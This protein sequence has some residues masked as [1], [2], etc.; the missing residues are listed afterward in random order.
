MKKK[1]RA[2]LTKAGIIEAAFRT[3]AE[4]SISGASM[5]LISESANVSKP[6]LHYHFKTKAALLEQVLEFVLER[7]LEIP[8]ENISKKLGSMD[9]LQA[10]FQRYRRTMTSEPE[11]LVVFFDFWVQSVKNRDIREII[12]RRFDGFRGYLSQIVSEGIE[13]GEFGA[14]KSHMIP[15]LMLSLLE[16]ASL[17]LISDPDAFN[18]DLYQYMALE[19]ITHLAGGGNYGKAAT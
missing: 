2:K 4:H 1:E 15:P 8:M 11:L 19:M 7:L 14:E 6:L 18:Y 12:V 10:I 17:Q 3:V 5:G 16:G 13:K 9:E